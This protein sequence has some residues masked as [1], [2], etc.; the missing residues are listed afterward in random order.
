MRLLLDP[1]VADKPTGGAVTPAVLPAGTAPPA[2]AAAPAAPAKAAWMEPPK[3]DA[4]PIEPVGKV[5][6]ATVVKPVATDAAKPVDP[7][8][9]P[10]VP[11]KFELKAPD[12]ATIE[13]AALEKFGTEMQSLGLTQEQAQKL[14][15]R[16]HEAQKAATDGYMKTLD[17]LDQTNLKALQARWGDKFPEMSEKVKRVFDYA[18]PKGTL[19]K[20]AEGLKMAHAPELIEFVER[21]V[22]LFE[23]PSLKSPSTAGVTERDTRPLNEQLVDRYRKQTQDAAGRVTT[24]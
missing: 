9:A 11:V 15:V 16:D 21:F 13:A 22:P 3:A 23:E 7:A 4:K 19:R 2:A 12:G 14:L 1:A 18:D 6:P 24:A 8:A 10:V 20:A 17:G 5:D